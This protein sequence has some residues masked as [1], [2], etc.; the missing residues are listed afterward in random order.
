MQKAKLVRKSSEDQSQNLT[1]FAAFDLITC[2]CK[3]RKKYSF[4]WFTT[5]TGHR[6]TAPL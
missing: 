2:F 5:L 4:S 1:A 6:V 3:K